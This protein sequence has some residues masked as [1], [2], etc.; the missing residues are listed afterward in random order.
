[1]DYTS[2]L[3][4]ENKAIK[5][6]K[7][8]FTVNSLFKAGGTKIYNIEDITKNQLLEF[9]NKFYLYNKSSGDFKSYN[10]D[11][12]EEFYLY[13]ELDYS[14]NK[15]L[16]NTLICLINDLLVIIDLKEKKKNF[17]TLDI[18]FNDKNFDIQVSKKYKT[19]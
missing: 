10:K 9:L 6:L 5:L 16:Y 14:S 4:K 11:K 3:K 7:D 12:E 15:G 8:Y 13:F 19:Y 1:M 17:K 18:N 2:I